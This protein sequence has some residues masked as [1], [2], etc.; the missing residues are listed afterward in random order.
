MFRFIILAALL[1]AS[2]EAINH[3]MDLLVQWQIPIGH[4]ERH[5]YSRKDVAELNRLV[6]RV[7][8]P[9]AGGIVELYADDGEEVKFPD[10]KKNIRGGL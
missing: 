8:K 4:H 2:L 9:V 7:N 5:G 6:G 3:D 10:W 1:L